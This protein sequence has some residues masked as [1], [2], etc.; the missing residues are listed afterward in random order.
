MEVNHEEGRD[1]RANYLT[2]ASCRNFQQCKQALETM[3][4]VGGFACGFIGG[5]L[6]HSDPAKAVIYVTAHAMTNS[7]GSQHGKGER[8]EAREWSG[9]GMGGAGRQGIGSRGF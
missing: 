8:P 2:S 5:F 9:R 6:A 3:K 7:G 1:W 4:R